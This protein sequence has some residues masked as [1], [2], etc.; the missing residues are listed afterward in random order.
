M[1][2]AKP[3][4]FMIKYP[5]MQTREAQMR[6]SDVY[7]CARFTRRLATYERLFNS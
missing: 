7:I 2:K 6:E 3:G 5:A 4:V 1:G